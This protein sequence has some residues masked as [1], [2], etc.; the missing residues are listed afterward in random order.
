LIQTVKSLIRLVADNLWLRVV[1]GI[2][3]ASVIVACLLSYGWLYPNL[4]SPSQ[5]DHAGG[6]GDRSDSLL[7]MLRRGDQ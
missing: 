6:P 5:D 3:L 7:Q 2:C 1:L 4:S